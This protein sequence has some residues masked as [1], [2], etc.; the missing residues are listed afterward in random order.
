METDINI[1]NL[2]SWAIARLKENN[3]SN[4]AQDAEQLLC[5]VL[6]CKRIDL[7]TANAALNGK[8]NVFEELVIERAKGKPLQYLLGATEF[9][10]FEFNMRPGV[11]IPRP[12][13]ELLLEEVLKLP[14][15][16]EVSI[17]DIG[18]GSGNIAI[19]L[20]K[21]RP[22]CKIVAIDISPV[23]IKLAKENA[24]LH[25]VLDRIEFLQIDLSSLRIN[26][27]IIVSNPPYIPY[28]D[29]FTL[30]SEVKCEPLIALDGG[31]D[32]LDFHRKIIEYSKGYLNKGG[33]LLM[34]MGQGQ[35]EA[36][37]KY[38]AVNSYELRI[39]TKRKD[40]NGLERVMVIQNG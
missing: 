32:G 5:R 2:L 40:Y 17:L 13:T 28:K 19:S 24:A 12:E 16:K 14:A 23:A 10:G 30:P 35:A 27:D 8:R 20:T 15:D 9:M 34:E 6:N 7:Y 37:N 36:L 38:L 25:N 39:I 33:F 22:K 31:G 18:T 1:L 26:F 4:P 29:L 21:L 3:I 11:F